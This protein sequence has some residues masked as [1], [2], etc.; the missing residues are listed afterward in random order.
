MYLLKKAVVSDA[1]SSI[2]PPPTKR[3][4]PRFRLRT[5]TWFH[6]AS[7]EACDSQHIYYESFGN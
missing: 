4:E 3:A 5:S 2:S 1:L 7:M 6:S